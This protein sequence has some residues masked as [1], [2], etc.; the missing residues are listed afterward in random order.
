MSTIRNPHNTVDE[1]EDLN[2]DRTRRATNFDFEQMGL[3]PLNSSFDD[4]APAGPQFN[5]DRPN[6]PLDGTIRL[7]QMPNI[8][9]MP[10]MP[11]PEPVKPAAPRPKIEVIPSAPKPKIDVIP[12]APKPKI[13][14]IPSAPKPKIDVVPSAPKVEEPAKP[15][16]PIAPS[17]STDPDKLKPLADLE[18]PEP[19]DKLADLDKTVKPAESVKPAAPAEPI[20]PEPVA[21]PKPTVNV[22]AT[23]QTDAPLDGTI[24][25]PQMP[26]AEP[27]APKSASP[28]AP[29]QQSGSGTVRAAQ[30]QGQP[31]VRPA[32]NI[33]IVSKI[34][35]TQR[36]KM[37]AQKNNELDENIFVLKGQNYKR[38]SVLSE[39]TGE[40][41][42]FLVEK[43][44]KEYV[45]KIYYPNFDV[46]KKIL[47]TVQNFDFEMVVKVYDYGKTYVEGKHRYY[48][49]M[50]YLHGGTMAEYKLEG[51]MD[52]FR[53]I[54]LQSAAALAYCHQMRILHKDI[55]PGNFF[56]RDKEHTE[57]VLGDFGIS[58]MIEDD[59]KAHKT[60]QARTP[61]YAAPE[62]YAD[63]ID[64][65][66]EIT[67]KADYYSLGISLMTL[68]LGESPM[69]TNER[70]MMRQKNEGRI[71]HINELPERIKLLVM[72]LTVVNPINR[73]GY[74]QVEQWF[75][76]ES[77]KVDLSSPFLKYKSFIVDPERNLVADNI[78]ELVPLLLA[79]EMVSIGYLYNG[80][81]TQ[82]LDACGNN[83]L[84]TIVKD[85]ITKRYPIDQKAGLM[86]AV[87]AMEPT[88]PYKDLRGTLCDDI[89]SVCISLLSDQDEY[90]MTL[91]NDNDPF[92]LYVEAHTSCDVN[93]LRSYFKGIDRTDKNQVRVAIMK[94]VL[95]VDPEIPFMTKHPSATINDIVAAY[96]NDDISED[97]WHALVDGRL[98][99]W[100]Y[101][102]E[103]PMACESLRIMI[104]DQTYTRNLA[105]K[106]L[107]NLNRESAYDLAGAFTPQQVGELLNTRLHKAQ[108]LS[109]KDFEEEMRDFLELGGR[110][111]YY[112][113]MHGWTEM[114]NEHQRCFD[115]KS[116][117]NQ[118]RMGAYDAKT[119]VYRF[120][121]ILGVT[122]TYTMPDGIDYADGRNLQ[123]KKMQQ[124]RNEMRSGSLAQWM[125]VFYHE[126]PNVDFSQEYAYEHAVEDWL[127][128]LGKIDPSQRYYK[129]FIDARDETQKRVKH[130]KDSWQRAKTKEKIWRMA[131][132]GLSGIWIFFV[133]IFGVTNPN[134]I[135]THTFISIGLPLGGMTGIIVGTRSFFKGYDFLFSFFWGLV[136]AF[137]CF[138]PIIIL[139]YI[140]AAHPMLFNMAIIVITLIYMLVC[141][142]TDFRGDE[143]ADS[144][145]I[146]EVLENDVKSNLIEPLYYT[147]KA[148]S[149]KFKGSK[150]GLLNDVTDQ[151]RSISGESVLHYVLWS[152]LMLVFVVSFIVFS[153]KMLNVANPNSH[154]K[155][156]PANIIKNLDRDA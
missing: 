9:A 57:L 64:G 134:Y 96:S 94:I 110:F 10:K 72:G 76:G 1:N 5:E 77:P 90:A 74:E 95:E 56:F 55:K 147:F 70:V 29:P 83:K 149:Y 33:D 26:T 121:R 117:E 61:I 6:R 115:F 43:D 44:K 16:E 91:H 150:F 19:L 145:L 4:D 128:A 7:P 127:M 109:D 27:V 40:A 75:L 131:F 11:E 87:Y 28:A 82:W 23:P 99:A 52:K 151:V 153:P 45:L 137:T 34:S 59:G 92:Y 111:A 119:A 49:L 25:A 98:L 122:P 107:Y 152:L 20:A 53:R 97:E 60:T 113:Q 103:D 54:V 36:A 126:D 17:E 112:A 140:G 58:S 50:E 132:F 8:D 67:P 156:A 100:M 136:G 124:F 12:S 24:R 63:V 129:R 78:H 2:P 86:A 143:K 104:N 32:I 141:H 15:A 73:W 89:H 21:A 144:R 35:N 142:L 62:M 114:Y 30:P 37:R 138:I 51:D 31:K 14:V 123:S 105:Y 106:V 120:C 93:R 79:N 135:L 85:I 71:P 84:S 118:E 39:N 65:V 38:I 130:V 81:I 69:S 88:Y 22:V 155:E 133:L 13:D 18:K 139:K 48:E 46:N 101:S 102:H 146:S 41:Q 154:M 3:S 68:W 47:Q 148:R 66:V 116:D 42:V 80:R 108:N 125:S